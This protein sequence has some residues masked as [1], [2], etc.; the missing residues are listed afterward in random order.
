MDRD[1][2]DEFDRALARRGLRTKPATSSSGMSTGADI[3]KAEAALARRNAVTKEIGAAK[4]QWTG[5]RRKSSSPS[6]A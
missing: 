4:E 5:V 2:P 1:H 3:R 6:R